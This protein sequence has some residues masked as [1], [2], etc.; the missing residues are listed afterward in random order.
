MK[1]G[2][3]SKVLDDHFERAGIGIKEAAKELGIS[4]DYD[5]PKNPDSNVQLNII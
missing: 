2:I 5:G 4:V 3:L 1:I